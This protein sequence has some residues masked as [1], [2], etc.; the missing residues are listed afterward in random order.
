[1][2]DVHNGA[3]IGKI[4]PNG[5]PFVIGASTAP[6][7]MPAT[8]RLMLGVNDDNFNDN[9]GTFEVIVTAR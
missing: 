4:G 1:M 9:S 2:S 6:I 3:L 7:R 5:K 8:G